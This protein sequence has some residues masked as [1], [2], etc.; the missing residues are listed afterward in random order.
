MTHALIW[1]TDFTSEAQDEYL[2]LLAEEEPDEGHLADI[3]QEVAEKAHA[4]G[5][6]LAVQTLTKEPS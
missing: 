5:Y 4:A 2:A 1:A 3:L 6:R